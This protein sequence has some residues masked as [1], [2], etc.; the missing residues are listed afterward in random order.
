MLWFSEACRRGD[1]ASVSN[2]C[3]LHEDQAQDALDKPVVENDLHIVRS[4]RLLP[5]VSSAFIQAQEAASLGAPVSSPTIRRCV[6]ERH[7]DW[8]CSLHVLP[9]TPIHR[10]LRLEWCHARGNGMQ[11]SGI[12]LSF[13]LSSNPDSIS[14]VVTIVFVY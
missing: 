11:W 9:L 3:H 14:A 1:G 2:R 13:L 12:M 7:L 6:A 4:A 10:R 5:T 8:W